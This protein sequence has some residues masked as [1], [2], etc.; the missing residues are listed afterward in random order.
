MALPHMLT[1]LLLPLTISTTCDHNYRS[2]QHPGLNMKK[3]LTIAAIGCSFPLIEAGS[4]KW[5]TK[6]GHSLE[7]TP[8]RE[9]PTAGF[10][11]P[12]NAMDPVPTSPPELRRNDAR[13]AAKRTTAEDPNVC[14]YLDGYAGTYSREDDDYQVRSFLLT[15]RWSM[16]KMAGLFVL[17]TTPV[18]SPR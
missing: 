17:R 1:V 7:W 9:T 8:P 10:H 5:N 13:L 6:K 15:S 3:L 14:G 18:S 2:F 11:Q 12:L 4:F 16:L